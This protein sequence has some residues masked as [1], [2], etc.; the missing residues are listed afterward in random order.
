[1]NEMIGKIYVESPRR[2]GEEAEFFLQSNGA[3]DVACAAH[4]H[5]AVELL[6]IKEGSY[7]VVL[8][9]EEHRV[10]KGDLI[11][12]CSNSIHYVFSGDQLVNQYYVMKIPPSFLLEFTR[13]EIG[14][15]YILRF[16]LHRKGQ[17]SVWKHSELEACGMTDI[18][19][20]LIAEHETQKYAVEIAIRLKIMEL[21]LAILRGSAY[22]ADRPNDQTVS[23]IYSA[24]VYVTDHYAQDVDE[25]ELAKRLGMSYSYFSRSFKRVLGMP[26][27]KYLNI[28]RVRKAEQFLCTG[29]ES[30]TEVA[31]RC[32][33]NSTSYFIN[34]YRRM[35]GKTPYRVHRQ[36]GNR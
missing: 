6:Y 21:L 3:A 34:V 5:H 14:A 26:F 15:E 27:R 29:S 20:Q 4:V 28:T 11:L 16:A 36:A 33:Y 12:F 17:K 32:G 25:R 13:R 10:E 19:R 24:M 2:A 31:Q 1:M 18:L 22:E 35:T 23:L 8:D 7:R 9:G 30:I